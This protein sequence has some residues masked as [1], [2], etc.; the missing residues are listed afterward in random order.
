VAV[1]WRRFTGDHE[2]AAWWHA[3]L[4][5]LYAGAL[6]FHVLSAVQHWRDRPRTND[7]TTVRRPS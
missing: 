3:S 6:F 5:L 1:N 2:L 4:G 7:L